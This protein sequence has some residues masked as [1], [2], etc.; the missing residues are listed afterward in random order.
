MKKYVLITILSFII[1]FVYYSF[2]YVIFG[3]L[4]PNLILIVPLALMFQ[5]RKDTAFFS[6]FVLGIFSDLFTGLYLGLTSIFMLTTLGL[7]F[8]L[9]NRIG[10]TKTV[11]FLATFFSAILYDLFLQVLIYKSSVSL[12][13]SIVHALINCLFIFIVAGLL[14]YIPKDFL[15]DNDH[16]NK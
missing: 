11:T 6:A 12:W 16:D 13:T 14:S 8:Q 9:K 3:H 10:Y 15:K 2:I 7:Y 1:T 4:S 5:G